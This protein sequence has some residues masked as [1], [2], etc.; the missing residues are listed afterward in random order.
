MS[1]ELRPYQTMAIEAAI[2]APMRRQLIVLSTGL[3]KTITGLALAK[4]LGGRALWLAHT[5]ELVA[6]PERA[7]GLVWPEVTRGI[8]KAERN[9]YAR[10]MVFASIQTAQREERAARLAL[11]QFK[12]VVVDEAHHALSA[13]YRYLLNLL[14]CFTP[15][16]PKLLGLTAT[17]E[18][19]DNGAL[20][21][22]FEGI[23]F[24]MGIKSAIDGGYL[25]PPNVVE[26]KINVDLDAISISRGDYGQ[27]QLSKALL[28]AGIVAEI[29]AGYEEHMASCCLCGNVVRDALGC[30]CG[31]HKRKTLIFV[32]SVEQAELV[33]K[34]LC[35]R[36]YKFAA[37]S[38][39]TPKE[40][41]KKMLAQLKSGELEGLVNCM[42]L[43]EGFDEPSIDGVIVARPT[44]SK[45]LMIQIVGRGLRL[46]PNK[47]D[48]LV[49]DM[50]GVSKRN[51]LVQ[52][53]VLFG[54]KET[55][56]EDD[57]NVQKPLDMFADPEAYWIARLEAQIGGVKGAPRSKLHWVPSGDGGWLLPA[58]EFGTVR[59]LARDGDSWLVDVVGCQVGPSRQQLS[60]AEVDMGTAQALA[61]DYVRRVARTLTARKA[62]WREEG[63]TEAQ[64]AF[65][66][67][68]GVKNAD[69]LT[70]G[71]AADLATQ[72][73]AKK[74]GEPASSKQIGYLRSL[75]AN[76]PENI[77]KREAMRMIGQYKR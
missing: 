49:L 10:H 59:M 57:R 43:T 36:G 68:A 6:Q 71:T 46:F 77:S 74:E 17:P 34:A 47:T 60:D 20:D 73:I 29:V 52:A 50:V 14:G 23:V 22:V 1:I 67:R 7:C 51:T 63:A 55:K 4:R 13:G 75:G 44:Q 53:A 66:R 61:E 39:E 9:E 58:A 16:G 28:Q 12:L 18:R 54:E 31:G 25:V 70:K 65:L 37:V 19:G 21:E 27:T 15:G 3:G 42:V 2:A 69:G 56:E 5:E 38:G 48:C 32:V 40:D 76:P 64:I 45:P 24:Q 62:R 33:S 11:Q 30:P 26:R 72:I 35:E 8:V 41:R